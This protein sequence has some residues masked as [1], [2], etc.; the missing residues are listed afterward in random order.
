MRS[1]LAALLVSALAAGQAP[2]GSGPTDVPAEATD[3]GAAA[4]VAPPGAGLRRPPYNLKAGVPSDA[5]ARPSRPGY[6]PG[7]TSAPPPPSADSSSQDAASVQPTSPAAPAPRAVPPAQV[8]GRVAYPPPP[9][10]SPLAP[11]VVPAAAQRQAA[12]PA[13]AASRQPSTPGQVIPVPAGGDAVLPG[14]AG[15]SAR[16]SGACEPMEGKF[17]LAFNKA[18]ILDLLEQASRWTCRNFA[19]TE[20]V[21]RGKITLLSKTPVTSEEAYAAF[22]AALNT[23]GIAMY[24]T[25][26]YWKLVRIA[27]A[28]KVPIPTLLGDDAEIPALEQP[29]TKLFRLRYVDPDQLRAVLGNFTSPQGADIATIP[30][31]ILLVTDIGLNVRRIEKLLEAL[32]RPGSNDLVRVIQ[33]QYAPARDVADKVNQIFVQAPGQPGKTTRRPVIGGVATPGAAPGAVPTGGGAESG[34][35]SISKV[36][37]DERTNKIIVISDEKSFQRIGELVRQ[38]DTPTAG[39]G[40]IHVIF[41]KNANAEDLSNTL[42]NLAS[43]SRRTGSSSGGAPPGAAAAMAAPPGVSAPRATGGTAELFSGDVKVTAD[44]PSNSLVIIASASDFAV[45]QRLI[46]KLDR[47]RR[48][49]FVEAVIMEVDIDNTSDI[50]VGMHLAVPVNTANGKGFIPIGL[51]PG[52][53]NSLNP[54]SALQLGGFLTGLV[55]PVSAELKDIFPFPSVGVVIQALQ[56]NSDV[57]VL[58]TPHLIAQDNEE[59][60]IIVGNNVP[61]QAGYNPGFNTGIGS[62]TTG[63]TT[64]NLLAS[65]Y[66]VSLIAPIQRQNVDLKLKIK[67]QIHEGDMVRM[68]IEESQEEIVANNPTLGPTT[69]KRSVKTKVVVKDQSTIV[70]GGLV[71]DRN[72]TSVSKIPLLGDIPILGWAF[73]STNIVKKKTNLLLLLTPYIIRDQSD[74]RRILERKQREH[75][76]LY[77]L[78]YGKKP[79]YT[80]AESSSR[81]GPLTRVRQQVTTENAKIENGGSGGVGEKTMKPPSYVPDAPVPAPVSAAPPRPVLVVPPPVVVP[82]Q[83]PAPVAAPVA[84]AVTAPAPAAAEPKTFPPTQFPM[85]PI[86]GEVPATPSPAPDTAAPPS[87]G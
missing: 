11:P 37:A 41:L 8:P 62:T 53:I 51:E 7:A 45:V 85:R 55:G 82:V 69:A 86:P 28:K 84:P 33:V 76:E 40:S 63:S 65:P 57:N 15:G 31:D 52:K 13:P 73:R 14:Q 20:E 50:G 43:G 72:V 61:F 46:D 42:Q 64:N 16:S 32:D 19:Y 17:L 29:V 58:S 70:I 2:P 36:V 23:N 87:G 80:L 30:P 48:Q 56:S 71:Q 38:L 68:D 6:T 44:K 21:V 54:S 66:A 74:F 24:Q 34:E 75:R 81:P 1:L 5:A 26:K 59:S 9:P 4:P 3:S 77:E 49:V 10:G 78:Y 83:P 12:Q 47:P 35:I 27:D 79:D 25:G 18:E 22:L 67:P 39:E 60:E